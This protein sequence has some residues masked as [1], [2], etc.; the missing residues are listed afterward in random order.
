MPGPTSRR[1]IPLP[2]GT[3]NVSELRLSITAAA[4]AAD[5]DAIYL[6]GTLAARGA[7]SGVLAGTF[8]YVTDSPPP[9]LTEYN[10]TIW[11]TVML[12]G[13]WTTLTLAS[14]LAAATGAVAPGAGKVG[15]KGEPRRTHINKG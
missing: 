13:A 9:V 14:G 12:A 4:N 6:S 11:Q 5:T 8:Y 3:D 7:L 2:L 1:A 10:G 15:G